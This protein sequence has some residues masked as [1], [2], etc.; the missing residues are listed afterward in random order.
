MAIPISLSPYVKPGSGYLNNPEEAQR[1]RVAA[2][3]SL[4]YLANFWDHKVGSHI[5]NVETGTTDI[6]DVDFKYPEQ[7]QIK[8]SDKIQFI[9]DFE[10][11]PL[12]EE[13]N[14]I[15]AKMGIKQ[16]EGGLRYKNSFFAMPVTYVEY[17]QTIRNARLLGLSQGE[18]PVQ[19]LIESQNH[20]NN[21]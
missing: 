12:S 16:C 1:Q 5:S 13:L 15:L 19:T 4:A 11:E 9:Q 21:R 18:D 3:E 20:Q 7:I 14:E 17:A 8:G 2:T 10:W 6:T